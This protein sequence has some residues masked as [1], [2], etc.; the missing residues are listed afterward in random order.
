MFYQDNTVK[1]FTMIMDYVLP[2]RRVIF[3][4]DKEL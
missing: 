1:G 2:G 3:Y 4:Q